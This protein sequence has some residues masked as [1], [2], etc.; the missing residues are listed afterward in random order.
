MARKMKDKTS[1]SK[2]TEIISVRLDPKLRYLAELA[3]R[4][5][6]RALSNFI[7]W[8]VEQ[9][10]KQVYLQE[11]PDSPHLNVSIYT[12]SNYLWDVHEADRFVKLASD[13]PDLLTHEEQILWQLIR[14]SAFLWSKHDG[15]QL[16]D[17]ERWLPI[18]THF[19]FERLRE[20][21]DKFKAVAA[22]EA[23]LTTLPVWS[24]GV[25]GPKRKP[26]IPDPT[27]A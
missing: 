19:I 2:R 24:K 3:A 7:E 11:N 27:N 14:K 17:D 20:H 6:R 4:K 21:W 16:L 23:E 12:R 15:T 8:T 10:L 26:I 9:A 25:G 18:E 22:G 1:G 13:Y 5:H